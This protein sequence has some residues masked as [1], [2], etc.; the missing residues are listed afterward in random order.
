MDDVEREQRLAALDA[1]MR[2]E[3]FA[4][5]A[6]HMA[7]PYLNDED[8]IGWRPSDVIKFLRSELDPELLSGR[9]I[10]VSA[11]VPDSENPQPA[12]YEKLDFHPLGEEPALRMRDLQKHWNSMGQLLHAPVPP[13]RFELEKAR[14]QIER[15]NDFCDS[16]EGKTTFLNQPNIPFSLECS[17][18][19]LTKR[20]A[21]RLKVGQ[22]INC[23]HP[24]CNSAF[25]ILG[26]DGLQYR[27]IMLTLTC[28]SCSV[29]HNFPPQKFTGLSYWQKA[30]FNCPTEACSEVTTVQWV[31]C[32]KNSED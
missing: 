6:L 2:I 26:A 17:N 27:E 21:T 28:E 11:Q 23:M 15:A 14:S 4:Y 10:G 30:T 7:A 22:I 20:N 32:K 19:H 25:E 8:K 18:G 31:L 9:K 13:D 12:D 29:P 1:R 3:I 16:I 5:N 24:D